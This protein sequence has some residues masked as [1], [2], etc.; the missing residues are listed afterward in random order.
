MACW[1]LLGSGVR[2]LGQ[3]PQA[4]Q[5]FNRS[6]ALVLLISAWSNLWP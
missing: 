6:L 2:C 4:W 5:W 3:R 1:A